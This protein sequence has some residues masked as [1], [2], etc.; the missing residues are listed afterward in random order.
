M[1][2]K[3]SIKQTVYRK[4]KESILTRKL[5]PGK[6]LIEST[7]S[8]KLNVS[9]TPIRNAID[10]LAEEGLIELIPNR[11]AF[12]I[13]P[14]QDEVLQAYTLRKELEILAVRTAINH[15][16]EN[17]FTE[18][19]SFIKKEREALQKK[20]IISYL[21]AN[22]AFHMAI[23]NRCRNKF[24]IE[25]IEKL[26]NKTSVYLILFDIFFEENSPQPYGYKEHQQIIQLLKQKKNK[27][28]ESYL[29]SHFD[30]AM[31]SLDIRTEYK[32]LE[33]IF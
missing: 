30:H 23:A 24:L 22:H 3:Q 13:N 10:L 21:E 12:V 33:D 16:V 4:L 9:R 20:D 25:F 29:S 27:E 14:T 26:I 5:A 18:M 17:D 19:A 1:N 11:G 2:G 15:L 6:Q 28:V 31:N 8:E 32:D 7:I